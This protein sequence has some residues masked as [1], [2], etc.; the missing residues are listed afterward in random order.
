VTL[1]ATNPGGSGSAN[2]TLTLT[3]AAPVIMTPPHTL[4]TFNGANGANPAA[5]VIQGSDGNYYGTTESDGISGNGTV[6]EVAANGAFAT[7]GFLNWAGDGA[8]PEGALVQTGDGNFYGTAQ[9]GGAGGEGEIFRLALSGSPAGL[10]SFGYAN[11]SGPLGAL[12][13]GTDGN[14]YGTTEG[15]GSAGDGSLYRLSLSGSLASLCSFTGSNGSTPMAGMVQGSDG[16]F[17]GT[18]LYGGSANLGSVFK[19]TTSGSLT[20][21]CSFTGSNGQEPMAALVQGSGGT[22]YGTTLYG[23]ASNLGTVFAVTTSGSLSTLYSFNTASGADPFGGLVQG[24]D[25][26]FYG[27]TA[28]GGVSNL[29]AIFEITPAGALSTL[30]S[31]TGGSDGAEPESGLVQGSDGNLYG[32]TFT[33]GSGGD[34]TVFSITP[35]YASGSTGRAFSYQ[36]NAS[37]SPTAYNATGLPA[38]L[39]VNTATGLI[40]GTATATGTTSVTISATNAGGTGSATLTILMLLPPPVITSALSATGTTGVTFSYQIA[41]T[42]SPTSFGATGLP[43]GLSVNPA[44]GLISGTAT[45]TGSSTVIITASNATAATTAP[46][47][48][49]M[50]TSFATWQ[51]L[52]FSQAQLANPAI[53]ADTANPSGDGIPNLMKYALN[54]NPL[55][56]ATTGLP[57]GAIMN[58]GGTNYL[59]LTYTQAVW[60]ADLTYTPQVSGDLKTWNSGAGYL[61]TVSVTPNGDGLTETVVVQDLTPVAGGPPQFIRLMIVGP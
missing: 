11:G 38:G 52:W 3:A 21:L 61:T 48:I 32:T 14:L 17:Y 56:S 53:S 22:L 20:A 24:L 57:V 9:S 42:N 59:T 36:I 23:G 10:V 6:F 8:Y 31:F 49:T 27:T 54:L 29:G 28:L 43:A 15:G 5:G 34:G 37:N 33:A 25:G 1:G 46:L 2:L 58:I 39:S 12:A 44:T 16:N 7:L 26:N 40:S 41:A 13:Q 19:M 51:S 45:V 60:A 50:N 55:V 47:G 30:Y 18:T 4:C 35:L